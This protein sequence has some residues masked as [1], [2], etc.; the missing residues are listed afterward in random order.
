MM[1]PPMLHCVARTRLW[2]TGPGLTATNRVGVRVELTAEVDEGEPERDADCDSDT[3]WVGE[4]VT[5]MLGDPETEA[6]VVCDVDE[7]V[8]GD[9]D[10]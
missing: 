1:R 2:I 7:D 3:D 6:A 9:V 10:A 4:R 5:D 8:D